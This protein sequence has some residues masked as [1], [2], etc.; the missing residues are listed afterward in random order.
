MPVPTQLSDLSTTASANG[1]Q[2]TETLSTGDDYIRAIQSII[3]RISTGVDAFTAQTLDGDLTISGASRR[4][5]STWTG[6]A[7]GTVFKNSSTNANTSV[8][9]IPS[10]SNT[11]A[12]FTV[13]NNA[14]ATTGKINLYSNSTEGGVSNSTGRG[15]TFSHSTGAAV[16][17]FTA[18]ATFEL[19]SNYAQF[20]STTALGLGLNNSTATESKIY[21][22][23]TG[24]TAF[25]GIE[26]ATGHGFISRSGTGS[27][28]IK[29]A[30]GDQVTIDQYGIISHAVTSGGSG[31]IHTNSATAAENSV[32]FDSSSSTSG[33]ALKLSNSGLNVQAT[34]RVNSSGGF[35]A[36]VNQ[37]A[38]ASSTSGTAA[39]RIQ[40]DF[41]GSVNP[42]VCVGYGTGAGG[43][44]NQSTA[45][46]SAGGGDVTLNKPTGAITLFAKTTTAGLV[47]TFKVNN[48]LVAATDT[49]QVSM[50]SGTVS[51][52]IVYIP[53][54]SAVVAGS[55]N[56][57]IYT[58]AAASSES[59]VI[60]FA[61]IKG[62]TS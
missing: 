46:T 20:N 7:T 39:L 30:S 53:V 1:P 6:V 41:V 60:N 48:S 25:L 36:Y 18:G 24:G 62:A 14:A 57:S 10:G 50:K 54:V 15:L 32:R 12:E 42:S 55:F 61:I 47:E 34:W 13:Y 38:A 22:A 44:V 3:K 59:P 49:I 58:P 40:Q 45:R 2:S 27:F 33:M 5:L 31:F 4:I 29:G 9:A 16:G 11:Y 23:N 19:G 35:D 56:L 52:S 8:G 17:S 21:V 43:T 28:K 26:S 37:T 51:G